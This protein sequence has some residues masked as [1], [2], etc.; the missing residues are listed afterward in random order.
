MDV[1][2]LAFQWTE[3]A[4]GILIVLVMMGFFLT[5]Y[6]IKENTDGKKELGPLRRM[7]PGGRV[8][9]GPQTPPGAGDNRPGKIGDPAP[10]QPDAQADPYSRSAQREGPPV[11]S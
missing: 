7:W 10:G 3:L 8:T 11:H 6:L 2:L 5:P 9:S 1:P 4:V